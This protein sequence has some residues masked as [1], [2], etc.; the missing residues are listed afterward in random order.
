MG[1]IDEGQQLEVEIVTFLHSIVFFYL[2]TLDSLVG[3]HYVLLPL[4]E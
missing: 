4:K 1:D 2:C 3:S